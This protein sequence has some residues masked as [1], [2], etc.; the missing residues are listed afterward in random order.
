MS[1]RQKLEL[2]TDL[3]LRVEH[4]PTSV[5]PVTGRPS[6]EGPE[7]GS[8]MA[9]SVAQSDDAQPREEDWPPPPPLLSDEEE[10]AMMYYS[11]DDD[12]SQGFAY[13]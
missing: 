12:R 9:Q 8:K 11:D 4:R 3:R 7:D 1:S 5:A 6:A 2:W 13:M 10:E